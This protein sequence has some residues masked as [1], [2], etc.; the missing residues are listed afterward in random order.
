VL[1]DMAEAS[2]MPWLNANI[3]VAGTDTTPSFLTPSIV[4]ERGGVK[5]G[6]TGLITTYNNERI[7]DAVV[8]DMDVADER[9]VARAE[10]A[11][12]RERGADV[13]VGLT[14]IGHR[15]EKRLAENVAGFDVI[16][17]GRSNTALYV[18]VET[19]THHTI[20]NQAASKLTAVG[21]LDLEIDTETK[22]ITG[23]DGRLINLYA[24]EIP[25]DPGYARYLDSLRAEAEAGFDEVIGE[26]AAT[27]TRHDGRESPA[28][29]MVTDAM[30]EYFGVDVALHNSSGIRKDVPEGPVT[31]RDAFEIDGFGN[32]MVVGTYTGRQVREMLELSVNERFWILQ[33]S[34]L[35][36]TYDPD[37]PFGSKVKSV[38]VGGEQLLPDAT[39]RVVTNSYL[40]AEEGRYGVF[41]DGE[42][43]ENTEVPLRDA[44][45]RYFRRNS[46]VSAR[47]EGRIVPLRD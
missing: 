13:I 18:P 28:G 47:V 6:I 9:D 21:F 3:R 14:H 42:N 4:L 15:Y 43:V 36:M 45:A 12:L 35:E 23:Y 40:G 33:V 29:N 20:V 11:A 5:L 22:R 46:P 44:I 17:G 41:Q 34:G 38:V 31:Y 37:A 27:L 24:E 16:V 19:P 32:T 10:I 39:Y 8:G 7:E 26:C 25:Q 1:R 2:E 30:R